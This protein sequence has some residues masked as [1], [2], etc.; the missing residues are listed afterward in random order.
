MQ[1]ELAELFNK[2]YLNVAMVEKGMSR[3]R[4]A[5]ICPLIPEMFTDIDFEMSDETK[6]TRNLK[7]TLM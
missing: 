2:A 5:G 3:F 4:T 7:E 6:L 1:Y